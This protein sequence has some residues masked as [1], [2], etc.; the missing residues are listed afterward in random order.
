MTEFQQY[1][2][3]RY[4]GR[5]G[6]EDR[7]GEIRVYTAHEDHEPYIDPNPEDPKGRWSRRDLAEW[8]LGKLGGEIPIV[9]GIDHA[10]SFPQSYMERNELKSWDDFLDDFEGHWPTNRFSVR[11]LLPG[12]PRTGD[13][14]EHRLTGRWTAFPRSVFAFDIQDSPAKATHAGLPWLDYLRALGDQRPRLAVRRLRGANAATRSSPRCAPPAS[15]TAIRKEELDNAGPGRLRHL[16]LA[17]GARPARVSSAPTS[18]PRS[19]PP[20]RSARVW[21]GGFWGCRR[22]GYLQGGLFSPLRREEMAKPREASNWPAR[23]RSRCSTMSWAYSIPPRGGTM[24]AVFIAASSMCLYRS[25]SHFWSG[26]LQPRP[27]TA[28]KACE[29]T[30]IQ[31]ST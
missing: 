9:V 19:R 17:P 30:S 29:S 31:R 5:K 11:E 28:L 13:P 16:R 25:R 8:L 10:F 14:D 22:A 12:N 3:V 4:S 7:I 24:P 6:P 18:R 26:A 2:G 1:I 21:R 27:S 15:A 20:S 23:C